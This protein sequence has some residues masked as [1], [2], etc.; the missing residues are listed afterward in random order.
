MCLL[1]SVSCGCLFFVSSVYAF[2]FVSCYF[3]FLS[4]LCPFLATMSF[5]GYF[6]SVVFCL[7]SLLFFSERVP[8]LIWF[9]SVYLVT[10]AAP[11]RKPENSES[12]PSCRC[13][14]FEYT[15]ELVVI[16]GVADG[17]WLAIYQ[18]PS[19]GFPSLICARACVRHASVVF[20]GALRVSASYLSFLLLVFLFFFPFFLSFL[21]CCFCAFAGAWQVF[22]CYFLP[23]RTSTG[24]A[25]AY[26]TGY[27]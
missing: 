16:R 1:R 15:C 22:L 24:L 18:N 9:G 19:S 27:D 12:T 17:S 3:N 4:F 25:T 14:A 8:G 2:V 10:T 5:A 26:I 23:S 11:I 6:S 7:L 21:S 20:M 13:Y